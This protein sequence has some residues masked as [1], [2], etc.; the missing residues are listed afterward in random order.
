MTSAIGRGRFERLKE[1]VTRRVL[2]T[3]VA[4]AEEAK[5]LRGETTHEFVG[6]RR[7]G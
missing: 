1:R 7:E 4:R 6:D 3:A 5:R 2:A